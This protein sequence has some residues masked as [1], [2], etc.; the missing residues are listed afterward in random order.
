M[1]NIL[2]EGYNI[3]VTW[4]YDELKNYIKS[5]YR[6][7]VIAFSFRDEQAKTLADWNLLYSKENGRFYGGIAG[8]FASYGI[9]EENITFVIRN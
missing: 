6:V 4:L 2:L 7:A 9:S 8:A 3:D 5:Y 1:I